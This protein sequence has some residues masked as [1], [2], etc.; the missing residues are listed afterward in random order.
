MHLRRW[1]TSLLLVAAGCGSPAG[2]GHDN[3]PAGILVESGAATAAVVATRATPAVFR[4]VDGDGNGVGNVSVTFTASG[5]AWVVEGSMLTDATG[6]V[7]PTWYVG[8]EAGRAYT[9]TAVA[10]ALTTQA[11]ATATPAASGQVYKGASDYVEYRAGDLPLII[12][13]PHGGTLQPASVPVRSGPGI[14]TVRDSNTDLLAADIADAVYAEVGGR[15]HV[16][17]VHLHRSRMD[18]NRALDEAAEGNAVAERAWREFHAFAEAARR[19]VLSDEGRGLYLD[20]HGHGHDIQR[21]EL[22]YLLSSTTLGGSD[23]QLNTPGVVQSSSIRGLVQRSPLT[24]A[25][26]IRGPASMGTLFELQGY[27]AVPSSAQ[28]NP[29]GAPYFTGGYNTARYGSSGGGAIDGV[30]V[31]ANM[32]GVRDTQANRRAFAA[33]LAR[34]LE[35][36]FALHYPGLL[37]PAVTH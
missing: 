29:G 5:D 19:Q 34:V 1:C 16:I 10:G 36:W 20:L 37:S 3:T 27:A 25:E 32:T 15:P 4:V 21:L 17:I 35:S 31:E 13:A 11:S 7:T 22:G 8:P 23:A 18:A 12:T 9:L 30:Q 6:R 14:V 28:P 2:P 26:L 33:A 24:H